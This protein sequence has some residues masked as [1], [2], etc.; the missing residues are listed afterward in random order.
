MCGP[1]CQLQSPQSWL[2]Q[3]NKILKGKAMIATATPKIATT[4]AKT[5]PHKPM[6]SPN[7]APPSAIHIGNVKTR[8]ITTSKGEVEFWVRVAIIVDWSPHQ[9]RIALLP[10]NFSN[11]ALLAFNEGFI[12][13]WCL[14]RTHLLYHYEQQIL[15][16]RTVRSISPIVPIGTH[17]AFILVQTVEKWRRLEF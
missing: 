4:T 3:P 1:T 10:H 6:I 15:Q 2:P 8:R 13:S 12:C 7:N 17:L 14:S 5:A 11:S 16:I 9:A